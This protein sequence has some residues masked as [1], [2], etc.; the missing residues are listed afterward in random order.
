MDL[1]TVQKILN[2]TQSPRATIERP[3]KFISIVVLKVPLIFKTVK[4]LVDYLFSKITSCV[5]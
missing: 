5:A 2:K 3:T 4:C 1:N